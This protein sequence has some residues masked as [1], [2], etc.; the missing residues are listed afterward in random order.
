MARDIESVDDALHARR[1]ARKPGGFSLGR[2]AGV[3][4]VADW[5]LLIIFALILINLGAGVFPAWHPDWSAGLVWIVALL[6]AVLFF[7]SIALHELAH[8]VVA[9]R[10]GIPVRRITLFVFGGMAHMEREPPSPRA[11]LLMAAIG[12]IVSLI[13]GLAS[14]AVG[15]ALASDAVARYGDDPVLMA[16]ALGPISTLLLWLGPLNVLLGVFNLVP[17]FPL[18]GGRVLRAILWW[19]TGNLERATRWASGVGRVFAWTLMALGV[20]MLFGLWVPFFGTGPIQGLWFLLI[21]WFLNNAARASYQQLLVRSAFEDVTVADVMR[22]QAQVVAPD[23][24]LEQLVRDYFM[25][26]DQQAFPVVDGDGQLLGLVEIEH[27]RAVPPAQWSQVTLGEIMTP[28]DRVD[29]I[30]PEQDAIQAL[31]RLADHE[32]I[33]VI[34]HGRVAGVLRRQDLMRWLALRTE[35]SP[36]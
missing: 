9:R 20:S 27:V 29:A 22:R 18:D 33:P 8:A 4:L 5:S 23:L 12:P 6:A 15:S 2:I 3:E 13:I 19:R 26:S 1:G 28:A 11:E 34:V 36:A 31:H 14:I 32:Q 25:Q 16:R 17:G 7:V 30:T 21:G 35:L 10:H 24:T